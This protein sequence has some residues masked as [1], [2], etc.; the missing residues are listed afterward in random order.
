M[1]KIL[2]V[3]SI[4]R[5]G[6]K[7]FPIIPELVKHFSV[8]LLTVNEMCFDYEWYGNKD[9]RL[10]FF[11]RWGDYF[12]ESYETSFKDVKAGKLDLTPYKFIR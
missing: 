3:A 2:F 4:Y 5:T 7:L 8:D 11:D 9:L 12:D 6:E 10:Q 1:D